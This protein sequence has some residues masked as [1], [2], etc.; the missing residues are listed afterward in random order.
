[1]SGNSPTSGFVRPSDEQWAAIKL[2]KRWWANPSGSQI[3]TLAGYAGTGK[4]TV[5][6]R[7]IEELGIAPERVAY[8]TF[9][10]KAAHVLNQKGCPAYTIHRLI[11]DP[12]LSS[13]TDAPTG[14]KKSRVAGFTLRQTLNVEH[15]VD[16]IVID[17]ISMV[18]GVLLDQLLT[19][20]KR[21]LAVGDPAQLPPVM[22]VN[23]GL[24]LHPDAFLKEIHRQAKDNPILWAS[25][26]A[27]EGKMVPFGR[28][29]E[30]LEVLPHYAIAPETAYEV[31]QIITCRHKSRRRYNEWMRTTFNRV[32]LPQVGEKM[33]SLK[34]RW[35]DIAGTTPLINGLQVIVQREIK[36][37]DINRNAR[38]VSM[39]VAADGD[40]D[41]V[42]YWLPSNLD[43]F[44]PIPERDA[45]TDGDLAQFDYGYAI[46]CHKSQGSEWDH[47]LYVNDGFGDDEQRA[48]LLYT[49]ITRASKSLVIG[50]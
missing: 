4:S 8:A 48:Q 34:N 30:T 10:G 23:N 33:I 37:D 31:D 46:T 12:I 29:G 21:V 7:T 6:K 47:V 14:I 43:F 22:G 25:M 20:G 42:W 27:R 26:L 40:P 16:L 17:E 36:E 32:G 50:I 41:T 5:I 9:T 15:D 35:E 3:C 11:Y 45:N 1:M 24:L 13:Y 19:F 28:H 44:E 2:I 18:S 39:T 49:G 38:S